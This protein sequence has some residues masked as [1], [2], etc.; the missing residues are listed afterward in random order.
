MRE[1]ELHQSFNFSFLMSPWIAGEMQQVIDDSLD[2]VAE[3]AAP[4]TWVLSN[5]DVVRHA[6]RLGYDPV[7]GL[8]RMEGIGADDPQPDAEVGLRR[9]RA[10]TAVMLALPGSA[11][12][13]Q[14]EELG[15]PEATQLPDDVREDPTWEKSGH[16]SR[17]RDGCRVPVPWEGDA[18]AFGFGPSPESWLPQP[19]VYGDLAVDRQAG[20]EGSTLEL[21]RTLLRL[22]REL[23]TG[24]GELTWLDLGEH[25]LAFEVSTESGAPVQVI[26]N[27][28]GDPVPLPDG[29]EILVASGEVDPAVGV[30]EDCAVWVR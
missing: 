20:V 3:Y 25:A 2:A 24:R 15:L 27:V 13:Y 9:A 14:G 12:L 1:D 30:P 16:T 19:E 6:S 23:R 4:Q 29:V 17:G 5:H 10:A 7:P 11:Y 22:R 26:A 28:G 8:L 21:Y 18:P